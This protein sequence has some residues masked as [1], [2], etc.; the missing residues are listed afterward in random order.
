MP[1]ETLEISKGKKLI[2]WSME[3]PNVHLTKIMNKRHGLMILFL[4]LCGLLNSSAQSWKPIAVAGFELFNVSQFSCENRIKFT[5]TSKIINPCHSASDSCDTLTQWKW[6]FGD[7]N[8]SQSQSPIHTYTA[9]GY[10]TITLKIITKYGNVDSA[11]SIIFISGPMPAFKVLSDTLLELGD[12]AKFE[13]TSLF[14]LYNPS[15]IWNFGDNSSNST[16]VHNQGVVHL[17]HST[18]TFSVFLEMFDNINGTNI[19]CSSLFPDTI[20]GHKKKINITVRNTSKTEKITTSNFYVFPN[21][22]ND[23]LHIKGLVKGDLII[24]DL[25]GMGVLQFNI[26]NGESIDISS[27]AKGIYFIKCISG[28]HTRLGKFIKN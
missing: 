16:N 6:D 18:G 24:Y 19:R 15:W 7:G 3:L 1:F 13:N 14:P 11:N 27:L 25:L 17:Y 23:Y 12:T 22:T 28:G 20:N 8:T 5:D 26:Q 9:K 21:P 2:S 4:T 10:F